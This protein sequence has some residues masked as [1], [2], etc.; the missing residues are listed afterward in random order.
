MQTWLALVVLLA[1]HV[2]AEVA[3]PVS[4]DYAQ[5][6]QS[7]F[8]FPQVEFINRKPA[9]GLRRTGALTLDPRVDIG[10][11]AWI[12]IDQD[13]RLLNVV[14]VGGR[15]L[16]FLLSG[17]RQIKDFF[18]RPPTTLVALDT[19]GKLLQFN[20]NEGATKWTRRLMVRAQKLGGSVC[21]VGAAVA[22][23]ALWFRVAPTEID[24][25]LSAV[26]GTVGVTMAHAF[27]EL[28]VFDV[29]N[30]RTDGLRDL[31]VVVSEFR[32]SEFERGTYGH[33]EDYTLTTRDGSHSLNAILGDRLRVSTRGF[34]TDCAYALIPDGKNRMED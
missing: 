8:T 17:D 28:N 10:E 16:A 18:F 22:T 20:W 30:E 9:F 32:R 27:A 13:K 34:G 31:G 5:T 3:P 6:V 29:N 11:N 33:I 24:V 23:Y 4:C 14:K 7:P 1:F 2:K 15:T 26:F 19:D 25:W 12:G 21:V